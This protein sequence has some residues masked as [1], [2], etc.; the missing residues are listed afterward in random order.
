M[1]S[2]GMPDV[3]EGRGVARR[4]NASD[5][6]KAFAGYPPLAAPQQQQPTQGAFNGGVLVDGAGSGRSDNVPATMDVPGDTRLS[7]GE[8][9]IPADVVS[10]MG[11]GSTDAG[12]EV[13]NNLVEEAR[14]RWRE[15][16]A[17]IPTP[18]D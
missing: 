11:E 16:T 9:V 2:A 5:I 8:Y 14:A 15:K 18:G 6:F 12:A 4:P 3:V 1:N 13:L 10:A 7:R 17:R